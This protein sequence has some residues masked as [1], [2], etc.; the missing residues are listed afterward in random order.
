LVVISPIF[1]QYKVGIGCYLNTRSPFSSP[2]FPETNLNSYEITI[3]AIFPDYSCWDFIGGLGNDYINFTLMKEVHR[4]LF[5][6]VDLY[7]G[8]GAHVGKWKDNHWNDLA[9][10]KKLFGGLDG[11][12]GLQF[13]F[14]PIS[15]SL[16]WRP[17]YS[18]LGDNQFYWLKQVGIRVCF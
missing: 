1:A 14:M 16:G 6:P 4:Q 12:F 13:T 9:E 11:T 7:V 18:F 15:I 2:D 17:V 8:L 5:Y 10:H 3:K